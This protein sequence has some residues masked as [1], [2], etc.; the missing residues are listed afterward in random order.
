MKNKS[1]VRFVPDDS[2][3]KYAVSLEVPRDL[4][5]MPRFFSRSHSGL[6]IVELLVVI[7]IISILVA[8]LLPAVQHV[9]ETAR[10]LQCQNNLRQIA[11]ACENYNSTF[12]E[13]PGYAGETYNRFTTWGGRRRNNRSLAGTPWPGQIMAYMEQ[14]DLARW[15]SDVA[16]NRKFVRKARDVRMV[17]SSL[18]SYH[19]PSR[20][21]AK[22][23]PLINHWHGR[24]GNAGARIDYAMN[25]GAA[26]PREQNRA[27]EVYGDGVWMLGE[28]IKTNRITDGLSLTY[29]I[30]EKAMDSLQYETG[31]DLGDRAP[32]AGDPHAQGVAHSYVRFA[33]RSPVQDKPRSC[34]VC[35]DFGSAHSAGWNVANADGSVKM[36][37]YYI[38]LQVHRA[39]ATIDGS[40]IVDDRH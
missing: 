23:Y 22:A 21:D 6:T 8:L 24:Y 20:R 18:S 12:R 1:K 19:C 40:E 11:L 35:H 9:R 13:L 36:L 15:L 33:A 38:D 28:R 17:R 2:L 3:M 4:D 14:P 26:T 25:G 29:M 7:S 16:S 27:I 34:L 5:R 31:R 10:I 30:G 32:I 39:S 37:S